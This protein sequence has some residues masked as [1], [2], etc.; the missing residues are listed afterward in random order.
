MTG[1]GHLQSG[2]VTLR[3][4]VRNEPDAQKMPRRCPEDVGVG[5]KDS[6]SCRLWDPWNSWLAEEAVVSTG[7]GHKEWFQGAVGAPEELLLA[8]PGCEGSCCVCKAA[9]RVALCSGL[10]TNILLLFQRQPEK[11]LKIPSSDSFSLLKYPSTNIL[12]PWT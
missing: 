8:N 4:S 2:G 6:S 11:P 12:L 9:A 10:V 1:S 5:V 7:R 3:T